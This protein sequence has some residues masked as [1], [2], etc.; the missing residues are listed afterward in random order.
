VTQLDEGITTG[1]AIRKEV[2][3]MNAVAA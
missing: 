1:A 2:E 3:S